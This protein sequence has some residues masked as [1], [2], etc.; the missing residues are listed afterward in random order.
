MK[1]TFEYHPN[2]S[3]KSRRTL[4]LMPRCTCNPLHKATVVHHLHNRRSLLRRIFEMLLLRNP[5]DESVSGYEIPG[6]DVVPL[7]NSCHDNNYGRSL[8]PRSVHYTKVWIQLGGLNN[9]NT[10]QFKLQLRMKFWFFLLVLLPF[11]LLKSCFQR[12]K[13]SW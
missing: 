10:M 5:L 8:N 13:K 7:C 1:I 2:W 12:K 9:H 4:R 6:W 11:R 3:A